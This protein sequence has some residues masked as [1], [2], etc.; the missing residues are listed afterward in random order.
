MET[1]IAAILV[2]S[3]ILL[4]FLLITYRFMSSQDAIMESWR[5]MEERLEDRA[6]TKLTSLS[7]QTLSAGS[8]VD[9]TLKNEGTTKL[10]DFDQWDVILEYTGTDSAD[11]V[12]WYPYGSA[13]NE[14][15][16]LGIYQ[17]APSSPEVFDPNILNPGEEIVIEVSV[18]PPVAS[19]TTNLAVIAVPNG[20]SA[21]TVFT[22]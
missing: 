3:I 9:I 16:V 20:I 18:S 17:D 4:G 14:W 15:T 10:S 8:L 13:V 1:A 6:R 11:H 19:G 12:Q 22:R 7:A 5:E 2:V 21:S